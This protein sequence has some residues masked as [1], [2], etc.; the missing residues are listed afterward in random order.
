MIDSFLIAALRAYDFQVFAVVNG[1]VIAEEIAECDV[2][3][4]VEPEFFSLELTE[5]LP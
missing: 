1:D 4:A 2:M 5:N 3:P